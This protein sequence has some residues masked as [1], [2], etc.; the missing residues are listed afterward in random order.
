MKNIIEY[1]KNNKLYCLIL[2]VGLVL[3]GIQIN[4]VIM[5]ADD[6]TLGIHSNSSGFKGAI[7]YFVYN[8][9]HWGGG[10]TGLIVICILTIGFKLWLFVEI[11]LMLSIVLI[12]IK[13]IHLKDGKYKELV[14]L[15]IWI[16]YFLISISVSRETIL[17]LDGSIAYVLT[18]LQVLF[19]TYLIYTRMH[20]PKMRKKYDYVL[21][22]LAA[23]FGGWSSA[24]SGAMVVLV[25]II[26][27][28]FAKYINKEKIP[29]FYLYSSVLTLIGYLIFYFAPGNS[30]RMSTTPMFAN[31]D[32]ISKFLFNVDN[33]FSNFFDFSFHPYFG[34]VFYTYFIMILLVLVTH[35][36][37]KKEKNE[38]LK[39]VINLTCIYSLLFIGLAVLRSTPIVEKYPFIELP[40]IYNN[41]YN[42]INNH[43]FSPSCLISYALGTI[44]IVSMIIQTFY[45]SIKKKDSLLLIIIGVGFASQAVMFMAPYHPYRTTFITI[46]LFILGIIYLFK[47]V[48]ENDIKWEY[49]LSTLF[50][51]RLFPVGC[52]LLFLFYISN[53]YLKD[54]KLL[55]IKTINLII[56]ISLLGCLSL[57]NW[58]KITYNYRANKIV[59]EENMERIEKY[60]ASPNEEKILVLIAPI[61]ELYGSTPLAGVD[62]VESDIILYFE[63]DKETDIM[64]EEEYN[65]YLEKNKEASSELVEV[66]E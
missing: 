33:I 38:L 8:Y 30:S 34:M 3:L 45:I 10:F 39:F 11:L 42:A 24:Q 20:Y 66:Y 43:T 35:H 5:Y 29:K 41:I 59:D 21:F 61:N 40:F 12:T 47:D 16:F 6:Y 54:N 56:F 57:V 51:I 7:D 2:F 37:L 44:T 31:L 60:K 19:Y 32:I 48:L 65:N 25:T 26:V 50:L 23:F 17:W 28:L 36:L 55:K 58:A 22:P 49:A 53:E 27:W 4:Q 1:I 15:L 52:I 62:W 63:L 9:L 13:F 46:M 18:S 14:A 64:F